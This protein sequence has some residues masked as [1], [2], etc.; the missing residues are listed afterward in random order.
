[1][2]RYSRIRRLL[3]I[4]PFAILAIF[5]FGGV[6]MWLWNNVLVPV[7]HVSTITF[8]QGFGILILSKILFSSF[9][10]TPG[11]A[12]RSYYWKQRLM[13]DRM[14]PEQQEQ[15]KEEW[16][17]RCGRWGYRRAEPESGTTV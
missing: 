1:M 2:Y 15:F 7:V 4:I 13:W 5:I 17:K 16:K 11:T 10:G 12:Y 9:R 3:I 14:T 6:L 8:W